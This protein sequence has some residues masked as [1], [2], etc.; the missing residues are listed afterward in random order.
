MCQDVDV[1]FLLHGSF[2]ALLQAL[3]VLL[4]RA[5]GVPRLATSPPQRAVSQYVLGVRLCKNNRES[6][7]TKA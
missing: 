5:D 2:L 4:Q 3:P 7:K 1:G 6:D